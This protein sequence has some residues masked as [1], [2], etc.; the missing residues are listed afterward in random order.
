[1]PV[2]RP[3]RP[4]QKAVALCRLAVAWAVSISFGLGFLLCMPILGS[5]RL[6]L[7]LRTRWARTVLAVLGVRLQVAGGEHLRGPAIF[8]AN[9]MSLIDV[10]ILP[11]L[12]PASCRLVAK[13]AVLWFPI[14]G[15]AFARGGALLIDRSRPQEAAQK[16][17]DG[18]GQLPAG[19]SLVIFPEGTRSRTGA[20]QRFKR[21]AFTLATASKLPIVPVALAGTH[22]IIGPG[23][24]LMYPGVVRV[25][26]GAPIPTDGWRH[27]TLRE[28][29]ATSHAA[30]AVCLRKLSAAG[31]A[32]D[33]AVPPGVR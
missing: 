26:V 20:L 8:I 4:L 33:V 13:R 25:Q 3:R 24:V 9:H 17:V 6:W 28:H 31:A 22:E 1:M 27:E 2:S 14:I 7:A 19:W 12:V 18:L 30:M 5:T 15:W 29:I 11:A 23:G 10:V 16:L 21:G 32:P